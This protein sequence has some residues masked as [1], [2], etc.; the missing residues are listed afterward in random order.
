M[1]QSKYDAAATGGDNMVELNTEIT[2]VAVYTDRARVTRR[3]TVRLQPGEHTLAIGGLPTTLQEETVRASG[4]GAGARILGLDVASEYITEAP[5]EDLAALR[6][7]LE[8]LTERDK[9]LADNDSLQAAQ[10]AYLEELREQS[11]RNLPRGIALGKTNIESIQTLTTF[12]LSEIG[13]A[14][15]RRRGIAR[16]RKDLALEIETVQRRLNMRH[17]TMERKQVSVSVEVIEEAELE[18]EVTY[19]VYGASW[20]PLYDIR[21]EGEKVSLSYLDNV[22]QQ[23]GEE[24]N[25]LKLLLST[26]RPVVSSTIPELHPWFIDVLRPPMPRSAPSMAKRVERMA[27]GGEGAEDTMMPASFAMMESAPAPPMEVVQ[28]DVES[29]GASVTFRV[30]RPVTIPSDGTPHKTSVT[31]LDLEAV[32]DYVTVP[33][34][35]EEAYLRATIRNNSE[36]VLLGGGASIFHEGDFVGRTFVET[37]VPNEEFE[38]QLGVDDRVKV[39]R[40][41]SGRTASK[42][43]IGNTRRTSLGYKVTVTNHLARPAKVTVHDQIPVS[44]HESIK[45]R[46]DD[47]SPEPTEKSDL[48][49]LKWELS[50]QPGAEGTVTYHFTVE[51]PRDVRVAGMHE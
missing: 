18:L 27:A 40:E 34:I 9:V 6:R 29:S 5:E 30:A 8:E 35:A 17:D 14:Q 43:F 22:R 47:V 19:G 7:Q 13:E 3:G 25:T 31:T 36:V 2:E 23:T 46:L 49:V 48:N 32:L 20:E 10:I 1:W 38:A 39:K 16:E 21:L 51:N 42:A 24:W 28:A 45:V 26:A 41:L 37:V 12:V 4:R 50:L 33:R 44:R 11:S 15:E